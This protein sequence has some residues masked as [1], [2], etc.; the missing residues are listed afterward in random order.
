MPRT[1][2]KV[3]GFLG[4]LNYI[5]R[6]IS[7][8]TATCDPIF[9]LLHKDQAIKWND[10]FQKIFEKIKEYFQEPSILMPP[11]PGRPLIMYLIVLGGSIG[12][13]LRHNDE[14]GIKEHVTYYLI[15]KFTYCEKR[16]SMLEKT[17]CS[18]VWAA[19]SLR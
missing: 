10:N 18:L 4:I 15:K 19:K 5:A 14:T 3:Y 12:C 6:F 16:Y 2:N 9:K 13:V 17:C 11:R 8:L 7:H 1:E